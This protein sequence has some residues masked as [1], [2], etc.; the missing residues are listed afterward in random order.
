MLDKYMVLPIDTET[1]LNICCYTY[2]ISMN[3]KTYTVDVTWPR[4]VS[5]V[6]VASREHL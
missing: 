1:P 3:I 6:S 4:L 2:L 5:G